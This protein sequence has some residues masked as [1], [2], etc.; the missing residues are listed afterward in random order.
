MVGIYNIYY[1]PYN[2]YYTY[3]RF[4]EASLEKSMFILK[5]DDDIGSV[6]V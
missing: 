6:F 5:Y 1:Y 2:I 4:C 3:H